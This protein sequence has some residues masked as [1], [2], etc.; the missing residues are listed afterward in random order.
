ML[1]SIDKVLDAESSS[2]HN[3]VVEDFPVWPFICWK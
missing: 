1:N 3:A 2:A